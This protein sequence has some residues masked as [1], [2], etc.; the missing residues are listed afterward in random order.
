MSAKA[1]ILRKKKT[2]FQNKNVTINCF[3]YIHP[4]QNG[5]ESDHLEKDKFQT[6]IS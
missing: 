5:G 1:T 2:N 6:F 3:F 4:I